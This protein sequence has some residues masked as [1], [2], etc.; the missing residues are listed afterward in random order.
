MRL[1]LVLLTGLAA[2]ALLAPLAGAST[3]QI[4]DPQGDAVGG[5][6]A[7]DILSVTWETTGSGSAREL[8]VTIE[9][10]GAPAVTPGTS[11]LVQA[12]DTPCGPFTMSVR[13]GALLPG[14]AA[15][16]GAVT[17]GSYYYCGGPG[18][19]NSTPGAG[20]FAVQYAIS[21]DTV[22]LATSVA[23]LP[24]A[25]DGGTFADLSAATAPADPLFGANGSY[26]GVAFDSASSSATFQVTNP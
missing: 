4:V 3:P 9:L 16:A 8:V 24:A 23:A 11:Y 5:Q 12:L 18:D 19:M 25:L 6:A 13:W 10:D 14:P 20:M 17:E 1:R 15:A 2:G 21:G 7:Q 22:S 26:F